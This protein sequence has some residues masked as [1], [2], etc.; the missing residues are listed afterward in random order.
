M[1]RCSLQHAYC[2]EL[3]A[4]SKEVD[5]LAD[6]PP[7]NRFPFKPEL[8][9]LAWMSNPVPASRMNKVLKCSKPTDIS[10]S[11]GPVCD[12]FVG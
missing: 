2:G 5:V 10:P 8:Q 1:Q 6:E 12:T 3:R 11:V 7:P 9:L 4:G